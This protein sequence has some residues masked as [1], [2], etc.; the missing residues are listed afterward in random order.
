MQILVIIHHE[1][2]YA[3]RASIVVSAGARGVTASG[4]LKGN[5]CFV[6]M[7]MRYG[8]IEIS[9]GIVLSPKLRLLELN[10]FRLVF[11]VLEKVL[12]C[13]VS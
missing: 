5:Y 3:D 2:L 11:H 13:S 8:V 10:H 7:N 4:T 12:W 6:N 1:C 9:S